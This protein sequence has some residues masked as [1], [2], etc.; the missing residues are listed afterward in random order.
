MKMWD[1]VRLARALALRPTVDAPLP[2]HLQIDPS[3]RCNLQCKMCVRHELP[4]GGRERL[5]GMGE[6]VQ[7]FDEVG[8]AVV[9]I[10]GAGEPTMNEWLPAMTAYARSQRA[11]A[12]TV[13]NGTL[14]DGALLRLVLES[15]LDVLKISI[16]AAT[17]DTYRDIRGRDYLEQVVSGVKWLDML[18]S[19]YGSER[20]LVQFNFVILKS[21]IDE[22]APF[23]RLAAD[24]SVRNVYF[25]LPQVEGFSRARKGSLLADFPMERLHASLVDAEREAGRRGV[26][27]NLRYL[28]RRFETVRRLCTYD[29]HTPRRSPDMKVCLAP[30][31]QLFVSVEGEVSPCCAMYFNEGVSLGNVFEEPI[32]RIWQ[33][34]GYAALRRDF[35]NRQNY[36]KYPICRDCLPVTLSSFLNIASILPKRGAADWIV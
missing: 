21:N 8:P 11:K 18:K 6:F 5:L 32:K 35:K 25:R 1:Y 22:I 26:S 12:I 4:A 19:R 28:V 20:P 9:T 34:E 31:I 33:S 10:S 23:V 13:T 17:A 36:A 7:V 27:T 15:G 24:L 14:L 2:V 16:D 29:E 3:T 30:W